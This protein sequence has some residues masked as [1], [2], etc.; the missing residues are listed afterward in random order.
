MT[1]LLY[2]EPPSQPDAT[3]EKETHILISA[4]APTLNRPTLV[5]LFI[6]GCYFIH[7]IRRAGLLD[8]Y[9]RQV[10][11]RLLLQESLDNPNYL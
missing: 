3:A 5:G 4:F 10:V 9:L 6:Y 2:S 1:D 11:S 8:T 7:S